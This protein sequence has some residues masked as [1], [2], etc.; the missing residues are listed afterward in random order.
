M[1]Q[2]QSLI[3][4]IRAIIANAKNVALR[5]IEN[6]RII[7]YWNIGKRIFEE[8]QQGKDRANYGTYLIRFLSKQLLPEYGSGFSIRQLERYRQ[9]Y[10]N[11]PIASALRTQL[12]WTHYKSLLGL[13]NS[14]KRE[15]YVAESVKN[16]WSSRQL[17]R[18]IN[19]GLYERLLMSS[20]RKDVLAIAR[21]EKLPSDA[22][23]II[24]DPMVLEFLDLKKENSFYEKDL[25]SA[26]IAHLQDFLLELGNGFAFLARQKRIHI[27]GDDFFIDLVFFNRILRCFVIVE[28]KTEKLTHQDLGQLQMYVNYHDRFEKKDYENP[29]IGIL[30]CADKNDAVVKITLPENNQT[31][32]AT[33]YQLYLPSEEQLLE[34]LKA[35]RKLG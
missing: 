24:K 7:M 12:S 4:E 25:E 13:D 34:Q 21:N 17:D 18:Q 30:L 19:S 31:I 2:N 33:K 6:E 9:F 1:R 20:N 8:E 27:D 28:I 23:E 15:F 11:F 35:L 16:N 29:S 3:L 5:A 14:D 32:I 10:R 22:R 26:I